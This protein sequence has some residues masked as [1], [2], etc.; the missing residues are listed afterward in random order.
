MGHVLTLGSILSRVTPG[1]GFLVFPSVKIVA[2]HQKMGNKWV[3]YRLVRE[4]IGMRYHF[5]TLVSCRN[6]S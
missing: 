4:Y 6:L 3:R 1:I 2:T 5:Y